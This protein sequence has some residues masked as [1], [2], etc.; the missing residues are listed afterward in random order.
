ML[1]LLGAIKSLMTNPIPQRTSRWRQFEV[2][3][4]GL[5]AGA[6]ISCYVVGEKFQTDKQNGGKKKKNRKIY[7]HPS[8]HA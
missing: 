1:P 8:T 6:V 3:D 4:V 5:G 7:L 2:K